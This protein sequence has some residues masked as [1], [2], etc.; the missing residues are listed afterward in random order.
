MNSTKNL[1]FM[2]VIATFLVLGTSAIPMQSFAGEHTRDLKSEIKA[3][4]QI[5]EKSA[6]QHLDQD[7]FCYRSD[8]CQQSNQAVQIVGDDNE[9]TGFNDQSDNLSV[10][11]DDETGEENEIEDDFW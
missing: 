2:A 5:E 3:S 11:S 10:S 9:A 8:N 7:N 4:L 6:S 1:L